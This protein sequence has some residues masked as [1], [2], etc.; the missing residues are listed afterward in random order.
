MPKA[1]KSS[2][3]IGTLHSPASASGGSNNP[4]DKSSSQHSSNQPPSANL[5]APN[6]T[7]GQHFLK[8]PAVIAAII[9][10]AGVKGSDVVLEVG[11]GTG[12]YLLPQVDLD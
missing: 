9:D 4:Y 8:N 10:K 7:L 5:V 2:H 6:T 3:R 12:T 11:P 1:K